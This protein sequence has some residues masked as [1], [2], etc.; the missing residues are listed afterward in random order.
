MFQRRFDRKKGAAPLN[1]SLNAAGE[2]GY[3]SA[4]IGRLID[5]V[6]SSPTMEKL[7]RSAPRLGLGDYYIGAGCVAQTVWNRLSGLPPEYGIQDI[8]LVYFDDADLSED[9]ER[10][11]A[12]EAERLFAELPIRLDVKNEARVHLW[13]ERRFGYP[14][15][16]YGSLEEAIDTWPTT[17]TAIGV[18]ADG[19]GGW[20]VYAPYGLDDLLGLIVR[21]NKVQ[22]TRHIYEAKTARWTSRWPGL[23]VVPWDGE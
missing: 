14:I 11:T 2:G 10:R 17:A 9:G 20:R 7:L 3:G 18:R 8:D 1:A 16:P 4:Q 12:L 22:I 6:L 23:N 21:P 13:Y 5:I 19:Q 15:E